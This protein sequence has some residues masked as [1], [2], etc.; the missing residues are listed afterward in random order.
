[1]V[2]TNSR[3][4]SDNGFTES[5]TDSRSDSEPG[6][7]D[8]LDIRARDTWPSTSDPGDKGLA[9]PTSRLPGYVGGAAN[10]LGTQ[11]DATTKN[12]ETETPSPT[13]VPQC[14]VTQN[15]EA[16]TLSPAPGPSC[17]DSKPKKQVFKSQN[18]PD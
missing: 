15:K 2:I 3:R 13:P 9:G 18:N 14:N 11:P 7:D 4:D 16:K 10:D 5:D 8:E 12:D 17:G 6:D 1:M